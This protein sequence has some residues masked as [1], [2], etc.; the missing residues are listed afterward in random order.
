[1]KSAFTKFFRFS[2]SYSKNGKI[3]GRNFRLGL[4]THP[5]DEKTEETFVRI[6]E[7]KLIRRIDSRDLGLHADFLKI[8]EWSDMGILRAIKTF[9]REEII[10]VTLKTLALERDENTITVLSVDEDL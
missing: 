9:L 5:M 3:W 1:M 6:V 7:E 2:A 10:P 4:T 8:A